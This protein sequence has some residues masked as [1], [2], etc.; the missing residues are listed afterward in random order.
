[1]QVNFL[2]SSQKLNDLPWNGFL[3]IKVYD[4]IL[5]FLRTRPLDVL[6]LFGLLC[7]QRKFESRKRTRPWALSVDQ[8]WP[9]ERGR[10]MWQTCAFRHKR[11]F[12]TL[13]FFISFPHCAVLELANNVAACA[14]KILPDSKKKKYFCCISIDRMIVQSLH[15][16]MFTVLLFFSFFFFYIYRL[17][18]FFAWCPL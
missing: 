7:P 8:V 5:C 2:N 4:K 17:N 12:F 1:M 11:T 3:D 14:L 9:H 13:F 10:L 15:M 6:V 18:C 16:E